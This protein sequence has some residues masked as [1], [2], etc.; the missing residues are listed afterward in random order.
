MKREGLLACAVWLTAA[1]AWCQSVAGMGGLAGVV[2]DASGAVVPGAKVIVA[3]E[4]RGIRRTLETNNAG[5]FAA[6]ALVPSAGY[7]VT[8]TKEGFSAWEARDL[9]I[10]VGQD[11]NLNVTLSVA[12]TATA[13]EVTSA[14]PI[15][16]QTKTGVSQVV[17]GAQ[18]QDLPINGRRVDSFVL[19]TPAVV[20]DGTY[21]L[22]SFRGIAGGNAFLTDGNDT[23][24]QFFNENAGRTRIT[25]QISQD[26]V[27]EFQVLANGYS[28]EFGRASGGVVN[29]VTRSGSNQLQGTAY[30]FFWNQAFNATDRYSTINPPETRHQAGASL[31]GPFLRDKLFYFFNA[32]VTRRDFPMVGSLTR[33]PLFDPSGKFV[34]TCQTGPGRAT[35]EQCTAALKV[36]ERHFQVL[37][38]TAN[39]ELGFG[40]LDWRPVERHSLSLSFN[41]LRW[42]SPN[43]IQ[44]QAVRNDGAAVGGNGDAT[45]R[46]R[47]GRL[48][49]MSI[50]GPTKLN[51]FRFG[52]FKDR[53][54]DDHGAKLIPPTGFITLTVQ[55][56]SN[57][58][59]PNYLPRLNPSENRFQFAENLTWTAGKHTL[60][61]GVDFVHT[62]DTNVICRN[63]FGTYSYASFTDFAMDYSGNATGG[64]RW[65]TYSQRF[66]EPRVKTA[67]RDLNWYA[68]DQF[69][70]TPS[71]TLNYGLRHEVAFLPQPEIFN[72][73]Y[74]ET[75]RIPQTRKNFAPRLGLAYAFNQAKTVLRAGYG[76][77]YARY[78]GGLINTF[79]LENGVYQKEISLSATRPD[80]LAAGPVFPNRLA[81]TDRNPPAGTLSL[82][83]AAAD[84]RIAYTQQGDLGLEHALTRN[85][86]LTVSYLWSRGA[87]LFTVRDLNMG[88]LGA[89]VTYRI[90]DNQG[91]QTGVYTT[92]AYRYA[93]RVDRRYR[94]LNLVDN[95]ANSY[96]NALVV[97]LR[98]RFSRGLQASLVYTWAHAIDWGQP[99]G[100]GN[101]FH[102]DGP[103]TLFNGDYR[104]E[105]G[106]SVLDQRHR[107]VVTSIY[108]PRFLRRDTALVRFL[109]NGWQLSQITTLAS[110]HPATATVIASGF[111][112][113]DAAYSG[114]LNGFGASSR[115]PFWPRSSLDIDRVYRTDARLSKI[116]PFRESLKLYVNFEAFNVFNHISDTRVNTAAYQLR[117]TDLLPVAGLGDGA[118]SEGFPDG[119]NARRAQVSLRLVF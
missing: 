90:L 104:G 73:D 107:L 11:I 7:A 40:K 116:L 79:F 15:V 61:L 30:W 43:G 96:Y 5:L 83:F 74:P 88:P 52:W 108:S 109:A 36:F 47:Y 44:T 86:G 57:L 111:P 66:G 23:T 28:A 2:R 118:A 25:A 9:E 69:R 41:Y 89:P 14:A 92:P 112:F 18:I 48:S 20:P 106:S 56:Q 37:D 50:L 1:G 103:S 75:K 35:P 13:V 76:V 87:R 105:K 4:A 65:T 33:P 93:N 71:L 77:F 31:G 38:R 49:W 58:G 72:P 59:V 19:L 97:Q 16:E 110:A 12:A 27:Q 82:T 39:Q 115:V 42:L 85:L 100:S 68:Q 53:Q 60:K 55:G 26:A 6:P 24:Q 22:L 64:K 81:G 94:R 54:Y 78:Q 91:N 113:T 62:L 29:T 17:E 63:Q 32:E 34:G 51:E 114:S 21:G 67:I 45:V 84:L 117:G 119:T 8:V 95:G 10:L 70:V 101:I 80:E 98:K 3:N 46:A 102:S 99:T